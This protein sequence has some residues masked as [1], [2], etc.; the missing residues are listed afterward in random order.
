MKLLER[1]D[2]KLFA[3]LGAIIVFSAGFVMAYRYYAFE[4]EKQ[5]REAACR[6]LSAELLKLNKTCHCYYSN[7]ATESHEANIRTTSY[8]ACDCETPNGTVSICIRNDKY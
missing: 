7:C 4:Q 2:V 1:N 5:G 8:C 6:E 3:Y